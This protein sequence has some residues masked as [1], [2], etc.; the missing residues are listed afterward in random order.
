MKQLGFVG[1]NV[2]LP[3]KLTVLK[4]CDTLSVT[5]QKLGAVNTLRF[6]DSGIHGENTDS[7][8]ALRALE[9][10]FRT[11]TQN[12]RILVL[13]AGGA[14]RALVHAL[15]GRCENIRVLSLDL[16]AAQRL[17]DEISDVGKRQVEFE[18]L[19][20]SNIL[21][22]VIW[23]DVIV[24]AT[25]V[26]MY[27]DAHNR[28]IPNLLLTQASYQSDFQQKCFFDAVF[29]PYYT[30]LLSDAVDLNAKVCSGMYMMIF[31]AI[32][33]LSLWT[34]SIIDLSENEIESLNALLK[35]EV[36]NHYLTHEVNYK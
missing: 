27:P 13:G 11:I 19:N 23:A 32:D 1:A 35:M 16:S 28:I 4:C 14:A 3:Y 17:S 34:H 6:T 22:G 20:A 29:N 2:T 5:A 10:Q 24:N 9:S 15:F 36:E 33:A 25:P 26:G 8:A 18:D 21:H 30:C 31:Q 7:P 12:D